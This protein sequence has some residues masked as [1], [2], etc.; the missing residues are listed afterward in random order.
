[1]EG[2]VHPDFGTVTEKLA[3]LTSKRSAIGGAAV[4]VYHRGEHL[5][6]RARMMQAWSDYL[7]GLRDGAEVVPLGRTTS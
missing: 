4:A 2:H 7:D 1:M 6:E 5:A 3:R